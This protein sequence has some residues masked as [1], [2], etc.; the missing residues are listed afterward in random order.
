MRRRKLVPLSRK[1][2][3]REKR[4]EVSVAVS[5]SSPGGGGGVLTSVVFAGESSDRSAAGKRHREG[6]AG[7][8]Q[9]GDGMTSHA[10]RRTAQSHGFYEPMPR[11]RYCSRR[12]SCRSRRLV[13]NLFFLFTPNM[14]KDSKMA[15]ARPMRTAHLA[16]LPKRFHASCL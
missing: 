16:P 11:L 14:L 9:A 8:A 3:R 13:S 5:G 10:T 6:T 7:Q 4:K 1:V 15:T 2:E 12:W